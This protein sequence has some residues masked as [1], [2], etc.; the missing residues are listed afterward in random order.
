VRALEDHE[1][2]RLVREGLRRKLAD[3][4]RPLVRLRAAAAVGAAIRQQRHDVVVATVHERGR[5]G[6]MNVPEQDPHA[7]ASSGARWP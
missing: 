1:V 3:A 4:R 2:E 7:T 5:P 6:P